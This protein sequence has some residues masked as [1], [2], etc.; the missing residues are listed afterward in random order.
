MNNDELKVGRF[1]FLLDWP[2]ELL[3]V[4]VECAREFEWLLPPW[5]H[6]ATVTWDANYDDGPIRASIVADYRR[7]R[8]TVAPRFFD[9]VE[10]ERRCLF[11]HE[12]LHAHNLLVFDWAREQ[13]ERLLCEDENQKY[14]ETLIGTLRERNEQATQDLVFCLAQKLNI[15]SAKS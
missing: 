5:C 14:R 7:F 10:R 4:V 2:T 13:I 12:V 15:E 6:V 11:L 1:L 3:P 8:I 9:Q